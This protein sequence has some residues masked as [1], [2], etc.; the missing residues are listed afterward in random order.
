MTPR[1]RIELLAPAGDER[2]LR[3]ALAAGADAVYFG[4]ERWSAR[5]FAG[6]FAGDAGDPRRRARSPVRRARPPGA[7]HAA[8]GRRARAGAGGAGSAVRR[9]PRRPHRRRPGL[10]VARPRALPRP[11]AARQHAAEH[12]LLG[13]ARRLGASRLSPGD[14]RPRAQPRRD[15]RPRRSRPRARGLRPRGALLR[16]LRRLPAVEHGRRSQRQPRPLQPVLPHALPALSCR[17]PRRD[18][19]RCPARGRAER[20]AGAGLRGRLDARCSRPAI[21]ARSRRFPA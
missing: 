7:Q 9:R 12:A 6:N 13:A 19:R 16:L 11:R 18:V 10:R 17:R 5:A 8:Q 21:S 2:A 20:S 14:P 15:R 1:P 3:A 4:L